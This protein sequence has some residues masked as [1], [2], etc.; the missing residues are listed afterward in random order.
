VDSGDVEDAGSVVL[1][2]SIVL[3]GFSGLGLPE[4]LVVKKM[5]G[6]YARACREAVPGFSG[7]RVE[8]CREGDLYA[9][10]AVALVAGCE[11]VGLGR[12]RNLFAA[13]DAGLQGV[14]SAVS[15]A[16]A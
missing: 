5:V 3:V 9:L 4:L 2:G 6:L 11:V 13:L 7:L 1:G 14:T 16:R 8:L 12:S 10:R 15:S